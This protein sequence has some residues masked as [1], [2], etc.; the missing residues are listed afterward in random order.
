MGDIGPTAITTAEPSCSTEGVTA[1][2]LGSKK[3][4]D[5]E[6]RCQ[7]KLGKGHTKC[8]LNYIKLLKSFCHLVPRPQVFFPLLGQP[9]ISGQHPMLLLLYI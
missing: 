9:V 3:I 4:Q 8:A 6:I 1:L 2:A 7:N 5:L